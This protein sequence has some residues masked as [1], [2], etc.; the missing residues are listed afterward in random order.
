[1]KVWIIQDKFNRIFYIGG[2]ESEAREIA[3][4]LGDVFVSEHE[5]K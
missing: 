2:N 3:K 1:M 5:V 4:S